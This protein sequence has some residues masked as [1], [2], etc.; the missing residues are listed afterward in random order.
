MTSSNKKTVMYI[1]FQKRCH[2]PKQNMFFHILP[3]IVRK[4]K[5]ACSI[6]GLP[7]QA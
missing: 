4:E 7:N 5:E 6:P 3:P 2:V 1:Y